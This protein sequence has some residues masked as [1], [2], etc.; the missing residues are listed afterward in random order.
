MLKTTVIISCAISMLSASAMANEAAFNTKKMKACE[1]GY[2]NVIK[3]Q[4]LDHT[5]PALTTCQWVVGIKKPADASEKAQSKYRDEEYTRSQEGRDFSL[6]IESA[7]DESEEAGLKAV[8]RAGA[9]NVLMDHTAY[10]KTRKISHNLAAYEACEGELKEGATIAR[11]EVNKK[12]QLQREYTVKK[13]QGDL[14]R[15]GAYKTFHGNGKVNHDLSYK[16]GKKHGVE[17]YFN[18]AGQQKTHTE[19]KEDQRD[20]K[21]KGWHD[22]GQLREEGQYKNHKKVGEWREYDRKG[23]LIR[24]Y[25][26]S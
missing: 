1:E 9:H 15:H 7:F 17:K 12:G 16:D 11:R 13:H 22:N 26:A 18:A 2:Q 8:C 10:M 19:F 5:A 20:G 3:Q 24:A 14:I 21:H 4:K 25:D 23:K 6:M